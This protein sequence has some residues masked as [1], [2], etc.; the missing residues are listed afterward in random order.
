V[1]PDALAVGRELTRFH[2]WAG[3]RGPAPPLLVQNGWTD[4]LFPASEALRVYRTFRAATPS[5]RISLQLADV[6][7]PRGQNKSRVDRV[8]LAEADR[9]FDAHLR[10]L[11]V[12][13]PE[14]GSVLAFRQ[15]CPASAPPGAPVRAENWERLQPRTLM[16]RRRA[17]LRFNSRGGDADTAAAIDPI[18]GQGAC[19]R[20]RAERAPG[21]AVMLRR[22][23]RPF[24]LLGLPTVEARVRTRGRGG[25][26]AA[27]LWDVHRGRQT[28]VS[29]GVYRLRDRQRGRV[30]FQLFG[31]GWRFKK[32]HVA[33]L[34][35]LGRDPN[36]LRTG[37]FRF[38][39]RLSSTR[40]LLPGR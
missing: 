40:V 7:H 19:V 18:G 12:R 37:N 13:P 5:S 8:M 26:I 22:V 15:T 30:L 34:E 2:S 14:H 1:R 33:K 35:L 3:L 32:G 28:L 16:L 24:T 20:V 9:F 4:D 39:V 23:R 31:N 11:R 27:R 36:F 38:S 10:R 6:G 29:R 17:P 21:T 25:L